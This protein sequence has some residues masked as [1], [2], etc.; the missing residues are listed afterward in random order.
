[1]RKWVKITKHVILVALKRKNTLL[2]KI[3]DRK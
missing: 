2:E 1:M 3:R